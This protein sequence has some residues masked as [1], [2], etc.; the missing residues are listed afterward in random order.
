MKVVSYSLWGDRPIYCEGALRNAQLMPSIYPGWKMVVYCGT[1]VPLLIVEKLVKLG[2]EIR[3]PTCVN[4]MFWRFSI[5]DDP[6]VDAF[7]VR[8]TDS[9]IG[10]REAGAV[11][12]WLASA[13]RVHLICDHPHHTPVISGG[14]WGARKGAIKGIQKLIDASPASKLESDRKVC[15]NSDQV[16]LRDVIWP[17]VKNDILIHDL[18][19]HSKRKEAVPFPSRFGDARFV[20]EVFDA[21]DNPR[22]F[23]ASMRLNFQQ[24]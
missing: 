14:L 13:K 20:G 19:Y 10:A 21:D 24:P 5:A 23:D 16:W 18:C 7:I 3:K 11:N 8:D 15:Y 4:G 9:R 22:S 17:M 1:M 12:E 6:K 2:V